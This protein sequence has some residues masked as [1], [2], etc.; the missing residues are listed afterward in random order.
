MSVSQPQAIH[1][2]NYRPPSYRIDRVELD[3]DLYAHSTRVRSRLSIQAN[4]DEAEEVRPLELDGEK[5]ELTGIAIDGRALSPADY[6]L[7]EQN[8]VI[9]QPPRQFLLETEA[10][11][12]P[13]ANTELS[14]LYISNGVFCTQCE[15]EGFRRITW[16]PDRP[17]VMATYRV[18]LRA[19]K[20]DH[21]VLL[22]NGNLV[23]EGELEGGRHFAVWE[24]PFPKPSYLFALV[25][26]DLAC[27]ERSFTTR[28]GRE[29]KLRIFVEHGKEDRTH[30]AM[31]SLVRA[32]RWD[33]ERFGLEYDL[34]LFN[35]VAVSDFNMGAMENKSL[36]I[37]N[38]KYILA[39]PETATDADFEGIESVVAHEYFHNWTGNRITCRD[40]FQLS[41][42][43]GLTVFRD[44]EFSA[45]MRS[46]PVKRIQD[47]R[48]LRAA[49]FP[50]DA[51]PL[52]HPVR[53]DSYI[54]INNFYTAT[55]YEKGAEVIRMLH[56]LL[57]EAGFQKGM[58]LYIERHDGQAVTCD[59]FV[60]AMADANDAD[61]AQFKRWY[62]QAGTP[63][64]TV[65]GR[66]DAA[67][68]AYELTVEQQTEPTPGQ[69]E[70]QPLHVPLSIGLLDRQGR[71]IPLALES[72]TGQMSLTLPITKERHKFV[73][74]D[75][76]EPM[77]LS[78]NRGFSAP[79][80]VRI[81]RH[82]EERAFLM[83]HDSDPFQRW[84]AGQEFA[85]ELML[86]AVKG[87]LQSPAIFIDALGEL[88]RDRRLEPAFVAEAM[89]LPSEDYIAERMRVID[90]E[91]I[92]KARESLRREIASRLRSE[93]DAL[94][95][96][97]ENKG[98]F[99]PDAQAAGRR[100]LRN[101]AL[102]FLTALAEEVLGERDRL[103]AHYR[104]AD[105]MTDRIAALRLLVDL[106]GEEREEALRDF[107]ARY[108]NDMLVMDKWFMLQA[109]SRLPDTLARVKALLHHP[110]F[111]L[112]RPNKVRALIGAFTAAN[113][114]HY[115]AADG[116]GYDFHVERT[117]ELDRIN[118][119]VA[120]R[121]L[122]PLGRWRRF[123]QDRQEKMK[124]ALQRILAEPKLSRDLYEIAS[125]ALA[126]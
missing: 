41:L 22:S 58:R 83:A 121:L 59:D 38:D 52:A 69:P 63:V 109:I 93:F 101:V 112:E 114:L 80:N 67:R 27:N 65:A 79:V 74:K 91:G 51:G 107:E 102:G 57:G 8:L 50:E 71:D 89:T 68:G 44:Q 42:K 106:P 97:M 94:Y 90:V 100:A 62:S 77:A 86:A 9:P 81:E 11:I 34:D 46:R 115:H 85:T 118:P 49:Q 12:Q 21:P 96:G 105:N 117:L 14:G 19:R 24:D 60:A 47:V 119:Q 54:E 17:D 2:E 53:P 113:P 120:A 122:A 73:F 31:D 66:Y 76:P 10:L 4:Y 26:G 6:Q 29:V 37:F 70:K 43:E 108:G 104:N 55:I 72:R 15:A 18:T 36:N 125:K 64:V 48:R 61:L 40:W 98:P 5:L 16:F 45:D 110:S 20:A 3:I 124:G 1:R 7:T 56:T 25:A 99:S 95:R 92:Y 123:N 78:L 28:S 30:Y 103:M 84:E 32:M 87:N 88:L 35:I 82:A 13:D 111:A 116:S 126:D 33:E 39:D 75:I 23:D